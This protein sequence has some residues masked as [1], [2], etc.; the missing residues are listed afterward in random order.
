MFYLSLSAFSDLA[1]NLLAVV[2][3]MGSRLEQVSFFLTK[4][5]FLN[6]YWRSSFSVPSTPK[7]V[8]L[9]TREERSLLDSG[10]SSRSSKTGSWT[11]SKGKVRVS[12][13]YLSENVKE[14]D[15]FR[16]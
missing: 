8:S 16:S 7:C 1:A 9:G 14:K 2:V 6:L 4:K 3:H 15:E 11:V 12:M 13:S 10:G 5:L